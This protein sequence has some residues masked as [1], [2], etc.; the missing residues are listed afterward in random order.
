MASASP[1][2]RRSGVGAVHVP[3]GKKTGL[4]TNLGNIAK[5]CEHTLRPGDQE[6]QQ[7]GGKQWYKRAWVKKGA[8]GASWVEVWFMVREPLAAHTGDEPTD[9]RKR[10]QCWVSA[11]HP[12]VP[13]G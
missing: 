10:S 6:Q 12:R 4:L 9:G 3:T 7:R 13:L 8:E 11:G 5:V 2:P 1:E